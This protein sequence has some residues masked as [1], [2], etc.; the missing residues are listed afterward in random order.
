MVTEPVAIMKS[1]KNAGAAKAFVDFLLSKEGQQFARRQ[2]YLPAHSDVAGPKGFPPRAAIRL[3][4]FDPAKALADVKNSRKAFARPV[5]EVG[6]L[7]NPGTPAGGGESLW[8]AALVAFVGIIAV[9]PIVRLLWEGAGPFL[10]GNDS[11]VV[12]V[13]LRPNDLARDLAISRDRSGRCGPVA[14]MGHLLRPAGGADRPARQ[15]AADFLLH[16]PADDSAAGNGAQL[17]PGVRRIQ[18]AA[19]RARPRSGARIETPALLTRRHHAVLGIQHAPLVFLTVRAGLRSLPREA[20]EAARM[21]GAGTLTV[22]RTIILPLMTPTLTVGVALAFVSQ[23]R[24]LRHPAVS[25]PAGRLSDPAGADFLPLSG[26]GPSIISEVAVLAILVSAIAATGVAVQSWLMRRGDFRT[27]GAPSRPLAFALGVWRLPAEAGCWTVILL[28]LVPAGHGPDR[29]HPGAG[30]RRAAD[31]E[32]PDL[33]C[34]CR[35]VVAPGGHRP[36]VPEQRLSGGNRHNPAGAGQRAA[37]LFHRL[38]AQPVGR[39]AQ[40]RHRHPLCHARPSSLRLRRS[41]CS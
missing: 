23:H 29:S 26:F 39:R 12:E 8:L 15:T 22:F 1:T 27:I 7:E 11:P 18:H 2:G 3:M 33:R 36:G 30:F 32:Q 4:T 41:W 28:V 24:Q 38:A 37:G 10:F 40:H 6:R 21:A 25:R 14:R 19:Q 5:R 13:P 34:L 31:L 20:V 16:D 9:L 35:G 17:D